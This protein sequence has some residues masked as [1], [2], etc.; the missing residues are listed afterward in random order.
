ML[1]FTHV[2]CPS[3]ALLFT[4]NVTVHTGTVYSSFARPCCRITVHRTEV[5]VHRL[6]Q[7]PSIFCSAQ[8]LRYI[9]FDF[10]F[11]GYLK[12]T[13]WSSLYTFLQL[14]EPF[15]FRFSFVV[16][17]YRS[18]IWQIIFWLITRYHSVRM[19]WIV[20]RPYLTLSV[21]HLEFYLY[22]RPVWVYAPDPLMFAVKSL[23][24]LGLWTLVPK[25]DKSAC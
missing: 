12:L 11:V 14:W 2:H 20:Q 6:E 7:L 13:H 18:S 21:S 19:R 15:S 10:L 17:L 16:F 5:T 3:G 24:M 8:R 9:F 25:V 23:R 1:L 22:Q 4:V